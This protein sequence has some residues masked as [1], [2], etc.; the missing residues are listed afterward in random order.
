M[1]GCSQAE[2]YFENCGATCHVLDSGGEEPRRKR[3]RPTNRDLWLKSRDVCLFKCGNVVTHTKRENRMKA[4][5]RERDRM[6]NL[7]RTMQT[8]CNMLPLT[9]DDSLKVTKIETLRMATQYIYELK[10][11]LSHC[12]YLS[13]NDSSWS[14]STQYDNENEPNRPSD[15]S[16][17]SS[18]PTHYTI[19]GCQKTN[20][21]IST[22]KL[23]SYTV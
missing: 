10:R 21:F 6:N 3:G 2:H 23:Q 14:T 15:R 9:N 11:L 13:S 19:N 4:N 7:N 20:N 16:S 18:L 5:N 17:L 1:M 22:E 8:L 12:S